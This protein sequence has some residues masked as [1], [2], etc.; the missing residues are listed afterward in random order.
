LPLH[1]CPVNI[2]VDV[3]YCFRLHGAEYSDS[4]DASA[5]AVSEFFKLIKSEKITSRKMLMLS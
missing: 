4:S 1:N 5:G 2:T 3:F